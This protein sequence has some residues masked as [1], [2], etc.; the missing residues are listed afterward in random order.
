M[1]ELS[2]RKVSEQ[3]NSKMMFDS[4]FIEESAVQQGYSTE[5]VVV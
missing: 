1:T 5:S 3:G 2:K 4:R